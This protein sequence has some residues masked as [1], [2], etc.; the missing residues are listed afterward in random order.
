MAEVCCGS[1]RNSNEKS[2]VCDNYVVFAVNLNLQQFGLS[3]GLFGFKTQML[4]KREL[5]LYVDFAPRKGPGGVT[6]TRNQVLR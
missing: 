1:A 2:A 3:D 4:H 5:V 6:A